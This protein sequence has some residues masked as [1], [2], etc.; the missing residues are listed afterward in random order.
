M[1]K[2]ILNLHLGSMG[3]GPIIHQQRLGIEGANIGK[4]NPDF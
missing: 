2:K 3:K 4:G 1:G